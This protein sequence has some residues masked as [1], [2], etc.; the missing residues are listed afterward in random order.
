MRYKN[1]DDNKLRVNFM[2]STEKIMDNLTIG[3]FISYL[4]KKRDI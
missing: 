4:E 2:P 1:E 3:D